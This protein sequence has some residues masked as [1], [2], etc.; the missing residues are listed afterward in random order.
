M[1]LP[2]NFLTPILKLNIK[3]MKISSILLIV[4]CICGI[5]KPAAFV[6]AKRGVTFEI[7]LDSSIKTV[8]RLMVYRTTFNASP[9][10]NSDFIIIQPVKVRG[11]TYYYS[12]PEQLKP[13]YFALD[14]PSPKTS[15][16]LIDY[17]L[18]EPGD[19]I[20]IGVGNK[21]P[22][23]LPILT[24]SGLGSA[25][26]NCKN[27]FLQ[28]IRTE[29]EVMRNN[30]DD[31]DE[32]DNYR[33]HLRYIDA[34]NK[35][36]DRY[37]AH[38][39]AFATQV[40]R[41]DMI[42]KI[43]GKMVENILFSYDNALTNK[44]E[45]AMQQL[46]EDY[47]TRYQLIATNSIADSCLVYSVHYPYYRYLAVRTARF[48][49]K[50]MAKQ[51]EVIP[52]LKKITN[53]ALRDKVMTD[54]TVYGWIGLG[55]DIEQKLADILA[56]VK[57][58][59]CRKKIEELTR[60]LPGVKAY[61]FAL[62]DA[63]GKIVK[64]SD[65][66][67]KTVFI[68]FYYTGCGNCASYY[69]HEVEGVEQKYKGNSKVVFI[70]ISA[71]S[72]PE[73]WKKSLQTAQYNSP[74]AINLYTNGKGFNHELI[75][76]YNIKGYPSPMLIDKNGKILHTGNFLRKAINLESAIQKSL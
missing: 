24:F 65:F 76:Y 14:C 66:K 16:V 36:I 1:V 20:K 71:D 30:P 73:T 12:M 3:H 33:K 25:K 70:S 7:T 50:G 21:K 72:N 10:Q 23:R 19:R 53:T 48:V 35:V 6:A 37:S 40:L 49:T 63:T 45:T 55:V 11:Y 42:G 5:A 15:D 57:D 4:L 44:S 22:A 56:T 31:E 38:M 28:A 54:Y 58:K 18:L 51:I 41:A 52:E 59:S 17:H 75:L 29:S 2:T 43:G 46:R 27:E 47:F 9:N 13:A 68:D 8:P 69:K 61:D 39:S 60:H 62:Q 26:Y 34:C 32:K 64:L 67:G 74:D